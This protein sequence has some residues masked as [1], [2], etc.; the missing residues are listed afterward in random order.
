MAGALAD[1]SVAAAQASLAGVAS[2]LAPA[3][4]DN[5]AGGAGWHELNASAPPSRASGALAYDPLLHAVVLFGGYLPSIT[6]IGD[7]WEFSN[8]TWT[9]VTSTV[10]TAPPARWEAGFAFDPSIGALV[11]FGGRDPAQFF[12]DTWTF[13]GT[14]WHALTGPWQNV[15]WENPPVLGL[16]SMT[17]DPGLGGI[18]LFGGGV[19]NVPAGNYN[20]WTFSSQ[21]W[22]FNGSVTA[23]PWGLLNPN[24]TPPA[25][26]GAGLAYD[27]G[28]QQLVLLGGSNS[29]NGCGQTPQE[30][31]LN[32]APLNWTNVT[33]GA[34]LPYG[35]EGF[36]NG[37]MVYD[38]TLGGIVVYGGVIDANGSCPSGS[39]TWLE[40]NGSWTDL[41]PFLGGTAAPPSWWFEL[42]YDPDSGQ[43]V[44]CTDFTYGGYY[45]N[46]QVW[47][48]NGTLGFGVS[49]TAPT[50]MIAPAVASLG[51][52]TIG[53]VG[54]LN[55][56]WT[57]GTGG[58]VYGAENTTFNVTHAG[59]YVNVLSVR[60]STGSTVTASATVT[61]YGS[62]CIASN[63]SVAISATPTQGPAPLTVNFS[64][65]VQYGTPP[66]NYTW[67]FGNGNRSWGANVST[68]YTVAGT[69]VA[70]VF[71]TD[72]SNL[73]GFSNQL[74]MASGGGSAG[75]WTQ[76]GLTGGPS[77]R[78]AAFM[79]YDPALAK[80]VLFG[81]YI[82]PWVADTG[83]TWEFS[84]GTWTNISANLTVAPAP[85]W[86]GGLVYDPLLSELVLFGGRDLNQFYND[87]WA[88]TAA[89]WSKV[90]TTNAPS[91]RGLFGMTYDPG[92]GAIV[93][94]G[95]GE[96]NYPAGTYSPWVFDNDT[97]EFNA[98]GWHAV[99]TVGATP[100]AAAA[101]GFAYDA[102]HSWDVLYG[103][104]TAP[105]GCTPMT[106]Q[107]AFHN[108]TWTNQSSSAVTGPGGSDGLYDMGF[109]ADPLGNGIFDFGGV[110][111]I[112]G[113][114]YSNAE[115]WG[116]QNGTWTNLTSSVGAPV[117]VDR[118]A[119]AIT[120]DAADG[121]DL[122]FGGNS[123]STYNYLA[124]T[125]A[126]T[127]TAN[128]LVPIQPH[129]TTTS[130]T[131]T[132]PW[133]VT[134]SVTVASG[135]TLARAAWAFGD[136]GVA[137]GATVTHVYPA[138]GVYAPSVTVTTTDGRSVVVVIPS[139]S[140]LEPIQPHATS[141][142]PTG[143]IPW[144]VT[145]TV[146][147]GPGVTIAQ[148][149]W[150]FGD[151]A[152]ASGGT[153]VTHVYVTVGT[154]APTVLVTTSD[155][156]T[157]LVPLGTVQTGG[158]ANLTPPS[159]SPGRIGAPAAL[160][161]WGDV[162]GVTAGVLA[163][164]GLWVA[165]DYR[166]RRLRDEGLDLVRGIEPPPP[167]PPAP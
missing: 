150:S 109:V 119:F 64:A 76:V 77:A 93:L 152:T 101:V 95:G 115:T 124:D 71:V 10:A 83:D 78:S 167:D 128:A 138:S 51:G 6:A 75:T 147:L 58:K 133:P 146:S 108:G 27:P 57:L 92:I 142:D 59:V 131:G 7:T 31:I 125:W 164:V 114:C 129:V 160:L 148:T 159:T 3:R 22:L 45:Y 34:V 4:P 60:D 121:Y 155:G 8:N 69:Y 153:T 102:W 21:T 66:Y 156:R 55:F 127:A 82:G 99:A 62:C 88:F 40:R 49:A 157:V 37:G 1:R 137:T 161:G 14:G 84:N 54:P 166:R 112:N 94:F 143:T 13:N 72:S 43:A 39:S 145:F 63:L 134:F 48:F 15:A 52:A 117:P 111:Q 103:G 24:G 116:D 104:T 154:Y 130:L 50:T 20:P 38:P 30:W 123:Y 113:S 149:A 162:V 86:E 36:S 98:T 139:V 90:T 97:W 118:H 100:P 28:T 70:G 136:G 18:V 23:H 87:T 47:V 29:P 80:V 110:S 91:P 17:Y 2:P 9:N 5:F 67:I 53:G 132:S 165:L 46:G 26:A 79:A 35:S 126:F 144:A 141:T 19:G 140:V 61:A 163:A 73:S 151:G 85:R 74:I 11:L 25:S 32:P 81:G 56:T 44:V 96:G 122:L 107:W 158:L 106:L 41:T 68:T 42:A 65:L 33:T 89:G 16:V 12:N 120:Y 105:N 135:V